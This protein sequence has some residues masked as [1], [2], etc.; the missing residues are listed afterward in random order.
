MTDLIKRMVRL[1]EAK[2]TPLR[3]TVVFDARRFHLVRSLWWHDAHQDSFEREIQPYFHAL[4][5]GRQYR[6]IVDAGAAT[7]L[8]AIAACAAFANAHVWAFEPS[9]R[10]RVVLH[11]NLR[12][13]G[14]DRRV[15]VMPTGLWQAPDVL[16]FRTHGAIGALRLVSDLPAALGFHERVPVTSLDAWVLD[17]RVSGIDLIKMDIEGAELEALAGARET[18]LRDGPDLLI[19][20]YHLRDGVRTFEPCSLQLRSWGYDVREVPGCAGLLHAV[21]T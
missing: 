15:D 7:G 18:L 8:F 10:Q 17:H 16:A 3:S 19:Q 5:P 2:T 4:S 1:V 11:R 20:A 9:R 13:N 6:T 12:L 14:F 21:R